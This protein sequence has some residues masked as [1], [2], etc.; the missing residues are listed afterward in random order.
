MSSASDVPRGDQLLFI[1]QPQ[2]IGDIVEML[3]IF[4][5]A[6]LLPGVP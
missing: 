5:D 6:L 2:K 3:G 4:A 1:V